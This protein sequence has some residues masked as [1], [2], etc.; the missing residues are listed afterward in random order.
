MHHHRSPQQEWYLFS[1]LCLYTFVFPAELIEVFYFELLFVELRGLL[2]LHYLFHVAPSYRKEQNVSSSIC[3]LQH[4]R[5]LKQAQ[6]STTN[7]SLNT[8]SQLAELLLHELGRK[9]N[10]QVDI[11]QIFWIKSIPRRI[12]HLAHWIYNCHSKLD[13]Y[14]NI[15][16]SK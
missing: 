9:L 3:H 5:L 12:H 10:S 2:L 8:T 13:V 14:Q 4:S 15:A 6:S 7:S 1:R 11:S 16:C